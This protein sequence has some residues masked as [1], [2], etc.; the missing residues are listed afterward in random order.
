MGQL[1]I[2][3]GV[4]CFF[5]AACCVAVRN[6]VVR[7]ARTLARGRSRREQVLAPPLRP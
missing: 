5:G 3:L 2:A 4:L 1:L 7:L 6:I